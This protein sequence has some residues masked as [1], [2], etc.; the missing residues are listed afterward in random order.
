MV[1]EIIKRDGRIIPYNEEKI[2]NA[3]F[4][5]ASAVAKKENLTPSRELANSLANEVTAKI[6]EKFVD[7][8]PSVEQI[9]D[10]VVETLIKKGHVKTVN[11]YIIYRAE[12]NKKR[13]EN[14]P[15]IKSIR[16]ITD[17]DTIEQNSKKNNPN[18]DSKTAMGKIFMYG[19]EV[20]K[21]YAKQYILKPNVAVAH[22]N[23]DIYIH[24]LDFS[25]IGTLCSCNI[26]MESLFER[27]FS[28]GVGVLRT[29]QNISTYASLLAI[30]IQANQND[31]HGDQNVFDYDSVMAR[32]IEKT[33]V[34]IY[35]NNV[36]K[37]L[38]FFGVEIKPQY[39]LNGAIPT[40][41]NNAKF[42]KEETKYLTNLK[43]IKDVKKFQTI[44]A[45]ETLDDL[46]KE[47]YQTN[48]ALIHTLNIIP[49]KNG[50]QVPCSCL[51]LGL[52]TSSSGRLASKMLLNAI[53]SG[54]GNG[55]NPSYP[56]ITFKVK[57]GVNL[58]PSDPNY[59]LL[60]LA[61]K[62][63]MKRSNINFSFLDADFNN[64]QVCYSK[65]RYR[66]LENVNGEKGSKSR[67]NLSK[68]TINLVSL[69]IKHGKKTLNK[70][71]LEGFYKELDEELDLVKIQLLQRYEI[72]GKRKV[73]N[74]PFLMGQGIFKNSETLDSEGM[75]E[76][77]INQGTLSIGFIG[78][79]ECLL[80]LSENNRVDDE[81][82]RNLGLEIIK[83]MKDYADKIS[84]ETKLN[85]NIYATPNSES[86]KSLV[87]KDKRR[88]GLIKGITDKEEY[89]DSFM[90]NNNIEISAFD[91]IKIEAPY[92]K[93]TLGGH[94]CVVTCSSEEEFEKLINEMKKNNVGLGTINYVLR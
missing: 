85:F 10:V 18:I 65:N 22:D 86:L 66:I 87:I 2:A 4:K 36:A 24:D 90:L 35:R 16:D 6:N 1:T 55:D 20:S 78:L 81:F 39:Y 12:R 60:K 15:I 67:G 69:G 21:A 88:Y 75:I 63:A 26:D 9:Q 30:V 68:T 50:A 92:H 57:E 38:A 51:D 56:N 23:G 34:K 93:L 44:V 54:I 53:E 71:D 72:Q 8:K 89:S 94:K 42:I 19:S 74:F 83:H 59:Y 52:D 45:N 11:A 58:K 64:S 41:E 7:T 17:L 46:E 43:V 79:D 82:T 13:T 29:P 48:E 14:L 77:V 40:L 49:S 47:V 84:A 5:A 62:V 61:I 73:K 80:A 32:G 76:S 31:E 27:G 37:A 28:T 3:I 70:L 91:K 25:A 33:Y